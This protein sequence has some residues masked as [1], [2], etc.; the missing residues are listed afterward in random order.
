MRKLTWLPFLAGALC[1]SAFAASPKQL[2]GARSAHHE[3]RVERS[4]VAA[5]QIAYDVSVVDLDTGKTVL[6]SQIKPG[7]PL[8]VASAAGGRQVRV[9][10]ADTPS[11]FSATVNVI[12]GKTI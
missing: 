9:R 12:Q 6:S 11:F 10:L 3:L 1:A 7:Q 5:D 8:D 2:L 4:V